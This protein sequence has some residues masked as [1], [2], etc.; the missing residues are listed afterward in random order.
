MSTVLVVDDSRTER[1]IAGHLLKQLAGVA[2][3]YAGDGDEALAAVAATSPDLVITDLQMPRMDGLEL[4][5]RMRC[6]HPSVPVILM[7]AYGSEETASQALRSGA[8]SYVP[9][10]RLAQDLAPTV[11]RTLELWRISGAE[12]E[13]HPYLVE[14]RQRYELDND[15]CHVAPLVTALAEAA[16]AHGI[17]DEDGA[18]LV[19]VAL[20]E[21]ISNAL[22]HGNLEVDSRLREEGM[23]RYLDAIEERRRAAPYSGRRIRVDA[24]LTRDAATFVVSDD[25]P[26]FDPSTVP[27]PLDPASLLKAS[28]RG[29]VLIQTFMDDVRFNEKG[30]EVTMVK[31]R[32]S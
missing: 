5:T 17:C 31:R 12:A 16:R 8:A 29:L 9:K 24:T 20:D 2:I 1:E 26:G 21:A 28:G 22:H 14:T 32:G 15:P 10:V 25:G 7:T 30:N 11:A 27:D 19:T 3:V 13:V 6:N 4:V 18:M 23:Q